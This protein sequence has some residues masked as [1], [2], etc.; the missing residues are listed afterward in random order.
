MK[1]QKLTAIIVA[2]M[3]LFSFGSLATLGITS[4]SSEVGEFPYPGDPWAWEMIGTQYAHQMDI[5]GDDVLVAVIDTGID[6]NHP[7]L[8]D[9]MWEDL[10]YDFVNNNNDPMDEDGHGTHV[11]GIVASVA[12]GAELMALKVIEE[13]D[14]D[15]IDLRKAI[16]Y[17]KDNGA[18]IITMSLGAERGTL[19][20]PVEMSI[21][22]AYDEG[23]LLTAAAGNEDDDAEFYPAAYDVVMGVSAVNSTKQKAY[24]SNYGDWIEIAAP[25]GGTEKQVYSTLP[26]E[27]YG[28]KI[29]TSMACPF[30]TGI[31]ALRMSAKPEESNEEV[32]EILQE[33]AIDLGDE[34][35]YGHGL[36]NAYL[37][38]G[39]EVPTPVRDLAQ[40]TNDSV[41]NLQWDEPWHEG[42]S[43]LEGYRI[44]RR[45]EDEEME[46]R[47]EEGPGQLIYEDT[48]VE[49]E[50]TYGY[51]VTAF[52]NKGESFESDTVWATPREEPQAP[53]PPRNVEAE[54]S[55]EGIE[56][57]WK[58]PLDD[59]SSP[60]TLYNI[61]RE[62]DGEEMGKIQ[63]VDSETFNYIDQQISSGSEYF[64]AVTAVNDYGESKRKSTFNITVPIIEDPKIPAP[65][66]NI[67][68]E[69]LDKGIEIRWELPLDDGGTPII[70]YKIYREENNGEMK[71]ISEL[72]NDTFRYF[73][74]NISSSNEYVYAIS[75]V[76]EV[77]E[78]EKVY[79]DA[80]TVNEDHNDSIDDNLEDLIPRWIIER[81][82]PV[83]PAI[84][85]LSG[86]IFFII[87]AVTLYSE[88]RRNY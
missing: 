30:T 15:W 8:Q 41:V 45:T 17:A 40:E 87:F 28:N 37:A 4:A 43:P 3:I 7:D 59:G 66:E 62:K 85:I 33:T 29:G 35:Y 6:Y 18:D 47:E 1:I 36:V 74:D 38:A 44:Y 14:G 82:I 70:H 78:S 68:T 25:G 53:E 19:K 73:D 86:L 20:P 67:E 88:K 26:D 50:V 21:N 56:I 13:R 49:N 69:L 24:Y 75:A 64:Y 76:N 58:N 51:Y 32:R 10:G 23:I 42:L 81:D 83:V 34:Y 71:L 79:S 77:G 12:P 52:N 61:Y 16:D 60:I 27:S 5:Y 31:A 80:L 48:D 2:V 63:E 11:A 57:S 46:L 65:P 55:D 9:K 72:E 39:G 22:S 84:I 54:L